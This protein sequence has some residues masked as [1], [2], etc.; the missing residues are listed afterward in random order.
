MNTAFTI[1]EPTSIAFAEIEERIAKARRDFQDHLEKG[2]FRI[3]QLNG[4]LRDLAVLDWYM[5]E[6]DCDFFQVD[7]GASMS[8]LVSDILIANCGFT[9]RLVVHDSTVYELV[10]VHRDTGCILFPWQWTWATYQRSCGGSPLAEAWI[11][12]VIEQEV[13]S[14]SDASW[15]PVLDMAAKESHAWPS[16]LQERAQR[17]LLDP[18]LL[19]RLGAI[20]LN[21]KPTDNL[22]EVK[23]RM[24]TAL[25]G[26]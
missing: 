18:L 17:I 1:V 13:N 20:A 16:D 9:L 24:D 10:L 11:W 5:S 15:H 12:R 8:L 3:R 19:L 4:D 7:E 22:L 26:Q 25:A 2:G 6:S 21:W 14:V 23:N